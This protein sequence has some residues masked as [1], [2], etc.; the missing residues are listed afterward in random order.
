MKELDA[1][2]RDHKF[3]HDGNPIMNWAMSNVV[4]HHDVKDNIYPRKPSP[5]QKID[6]V[7]ALLMALYRWTAFSEDD[8]PTISFI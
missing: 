1:L 8:S 2:V 3:H 5:E 7:V 6:P 4:C